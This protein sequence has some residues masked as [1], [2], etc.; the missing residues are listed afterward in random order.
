MIDT[1]YRLQLFGNG[2]TISASA[3]EGKQRARFL[4]DVPVCVRSGDEDAEV[5]TAGSFS[6]NG[7][8]S[9]PFE[10]SKTHLIDLSAG[11][12][13]TFASAAAGLLILSFE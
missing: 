6:S 5:P 7:L 2:T 4:S 8:A 10:A 11:E 3:P 13:L 12:R 9:F 1:V